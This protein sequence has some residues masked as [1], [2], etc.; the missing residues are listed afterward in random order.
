VIVCVDWTVFQSGVQAVT[1]V[2]GPPRE[3][4]AAR[5]ACETSVVA[6]PRCD[7]PLQICFSAGLQVWVTELRVCL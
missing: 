4:L 6:E 3:H 5:P 2:H 1:R 7:F